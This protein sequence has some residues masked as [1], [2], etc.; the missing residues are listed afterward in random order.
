VSIRGENLAIVSLPIPAPDLPANITPA[1]RAVIACL[2]SGM[3]NAE[4]AKHRGTSAR[5]V[6]NQVASIFRK[7]GVFSRAELAKK[8]RGGE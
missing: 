1:E 6:A 8:L 4:T 5:T 7:L 2:L 3:S